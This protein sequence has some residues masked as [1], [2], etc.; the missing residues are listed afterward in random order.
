MKTK[1]PWM[2][3]VILSAILVLI[4]L[5]LNAATKYWYPS[6]GGTWTTVGNWSTTPSP[7]FTA[8][9]VPAAGDD[10]I[11]N[12][13]Q[14]ANITAVPAITLNSL[15]VTGNCLLASG[16]SGNTITI[17][18]SFFVAA[19]VTLT[20][21][22]SGGRIVFTLNGIG[23]S[24][25]NIAFDAGSTVRNFTVNGTLILLPTGRI[26]DPNLSVG[27]CLVVNSGATLKIGHSGGIL[28]GGQTVQNPNVSVCFGG[29]NTYNAGANFEY[30]GTVAQVTGAG[31]PATVSSLTINNAVGVTLTAAVA[32][33]NNLEININSKLN[34]G[35][36]TTST[37]GTLSFN[38]AG[39]VAGTWGYTGSGATNI[40]TTYFA[41]NTGR[42]TV[43]SGTAPACS[44][45]LT[46]ATNTDNQAFCTGYPITNITYATTGATGATVTGLPAGVTSA[47]ASNVLTISGSPAVSGNFTYQ[48]TLTGGG[49][50][51]TKT[52]TL[53]SNVFLSYPTPNTFAP[54]TTITSLTPTF[55]T[56][57]SITSYSISPAL[58]ATGLTFSTATGIISGTTGSSTVAATTYTV[59][60]TLSCGGSVSFGVVI[61]VGNNRYAVANGNWN[62]TS[63]WATTSGGTAGA[64]VPSAGDN[65]YIGEGAA[66]R[67]VT[68]PTTVTAVC[69][70][71]NIGAGANPGVLTFTDATNTLTVY[72]DLIMNVPTAAVSS[73]IN[74]NA[75]T[76]TVNGKASLSTDPTGVGATTTT[77][78]NRI[79]ISTGTVNIAGDLTFYALDVAQSNI[80]FSGAGVLNLGGNF[81]IPNSLGTITPSTGTVNFNGSS[82]T[83]TIPVGVSSITYSNLTV[84]NTSSGGAKLSAALTATNVTGNISVGNVTTA[85]LLYTNNFNMARAA[86]N[87]IT[88]ASGSTLNAGTSVISWGGAS[89]VITINGSMQTANTAG[90]TGS[91]TTAINTTNNAP[92]V[93]LGSSSTIEYNAAGAQA[94]TSRTYTNNVILSGSGN[95]TISTG[96]AITGNLS[97]T[98]TAVGLMTSGGTST[99]GTLTLG[100]AG[101]NSGSW[102]GTAA[103]TATYKNSTYF[104]TTTTGILNVTTPTC[105]TGTWLGLVSTDWNTASNWC[106]TVVPTA[107]S[108]ITI[109]SSA[110]LQ[111]VIGATGSV[112]VCRNITIASGASLT[113]TGSN[114]L[115]VYGNWTNSGT[116]T[117][118]SSTV[119]FT[120]TG[121]GNIGASNFNN[122]T[123][124][125]AGTKTAT[126][127]LTIAG[128]VSLTNNFTPGAFTHTVAGNWANSGTFTAT[129]STVNFNGG[130]SQS[131]GASNF[132]NITF[133]GAGSKTATGILS[134]AGN[135]DIQIGSTFVAG[136]FTHTAGGNW[137]KSG[138]FTATGSTINFNSS[139]AGQTIGASNFNN[140]TF[141]NAGVK[142]AGGALAIVGNITI[143]NNFSGGS[144]TH[145]LQ[146]DWT[147]NGTFTGN[148]STISLNGSN[149]Q[150]ISG[151]PTTFYNLTQ[152]G[153]GVVNLGVATAVTGTLGL[154]SGLIDIG[155]YNLTVG[156]TSGGSATS[157]V[158]TS[159]TGRLVQSIA[160]NITKTYPVGNAAYNPMTVTNNSGGSDNFSIYVA[161]GLITNANSA[162]T[163]NRKWYLF[164]D[165]AGTA[166]LTLAASYNS[167]ETGTGFDRTSSPQIGYFDGTSWAYQPATA[168]GTGPFTFTATGSASN[169]T[170]TAGFFALGSGDAFAASKLAVTGLNPVNPSLGVPNTAITVQSQNSLGVPTYVNSSTSF[171][172]SS[173]TTFTPASSGTISSGTYQ[174]ILTGISFTAIVTGATAT[175]TRSSG[176]TLSPGTS[177]PFN[178]YAANIYEP[179]ATE[180]WDAANGWRKSTDGGG[181]W[182]NP[183]TLPGSNIFANNDLIRIPAGIT[184]TANVTASFYSMVVLGT[185]NINNSGN[186]TVN[187]STLSDYNI[188]VNGTLKNSGGTLTNN[189]AGFPTELI[190]ITGGTYEHAMNGGSIPV[191]KWSSLNTT[192]STCNITGITSTA[193]T[194]LNQTFQNFTW[195]NGSQSVTQSL[196]A[197]LPVN[198]TL[199]LT[200][201]N[202][203]TGSYRVIVGLSGSV[204]QTSGYVIGNVRRFIAD[205]TA[206]TVVFPVG[207][208][209]GYSPASITFTGSVTGSG[210]LDATTTIAA[211]P[212]AS[213]LSQMKY[214]NRK[215]TITNSGVTGFTTYSPT[216]TFVDGDKTGTPTTANLV[217]RKLDG[218]TWAAT[219]AGIRSANSTQCTGLT[220]FS[221]FYIGEDACSSSNAIWLGTA[222]TDWNTPGNWCSGSVPVSTTNV[223]IPS[224]PVN[225]PVLSS[226]G[227]ACNDITIQSGASLTISGVYN[228][229]VKGNWSNSG[230][231]TAGI[232]TISFTGSLAQTITGATTFNNLTI[233][234]SAGVTAANDIAVNG[235]LALTS[236]NP[237]ATHGTLDMGSYTLNMSSASATITGDN[238][239]SGIVKRQHTFTPNVQYSF[240]SQY[241]TVTFLGTGT[242]PDELSCRITIGSYLPN[243]ADA[244][245]RY[246]SF[247][248]TGTTG[249][250]KVTLNLAYRDGSYASPELNGNS[251]SNL[252][253]WDQH[254][255]LTVEQHGKSN[256]SELNNWVGLSGLSMSYIA[257]ATLNSKYWGLAN[258]ATTKNTWAGPVSTDWFEI[259]NWTGGHVPSA[260]DDVLIPDV[261]TGSN[262]YPILTANAEIKTIEIALGA[263][264]TAGSN[265][266]T[267]NGYSGAWINNGT[268]IPGTGSVN[269]THGNLSHIVSVSGTGT[270][271]FYNLYFGANT[272][273]RPGSGTTMKISG[274]AS[275]E[276]SSI[277]DLSAVGNTVEYNG[278]DQYIVNP[279]TAGF[280]Y[281]GFYNLTLSGTGTKT[282][283]GG[284]EL[285]ISGNFTGNAVLDLGSTGRAAF[286]GTAAQNISGTVAPVFTNLTV[287]NTAGV[288]ATV[289]I[290]VNDTLHL[291]SGNPSSL[292][293]GTLNMVASNIL[294]LGAN[295]VTTGSGDATGIIT[296][297]HTFATNTFYTFGN[298]NQ[299]VLFPVVTGQ[300]LP[301]SLSYRVT[302]GTV[303][304]W[305]GNTPA[306]ITKRTFEIAKSAAGSGTKALF[307]FNY[308]DNELASGINESLLSIYSSYYS[309]GTYTVTDE[310]WSNYNTDLNFISIQDKNVASLPTS[311]GNFQV[312][313]APTSVTTLTWNGGNSADWNTTSNW[314]PNGAPSTT[315]GVLIPDANTTPNDPI[316]PVGASCKFLI[317]ETDGILNS[318]TDATLTIADGTIGDAWACESGGIFNAGN[319]TVTVSNSGSSTFA[320]ISGTTHFY[321][322][323]VA[324][325][326]SVRPAADCYM[327]IAGALSIASDGILAA[328]TNENTIEFNGTGQ[329]IPNPNGSTPGYHN[330][331]LS[332]S[333]T[334]TLPA[335]LNIFDELT[336]N[337][338]GTVSA[339][340]GT[341][342]LNGNAYGQVIGGTASISF[343]NLTIDNSDG[344]TIENNETVNGTLTLTNG[345]VTTNG[346]TLTI[347]SAGTITGATSSSYINGKLARIYTATGSKSFP[348]GKN[349]NYRSLAVLFTDLT[350]TSTVTAEQFE[351]TIPGA[352]PS[353]VTPF[354]GRYWTITE[355]GSSSATF[356][357]T[358]DGTGITNKA[359][360]MIK[361][362]G[363]TNA[364]FSVTG[365]APN[366]T[367]AG[368]TSF[369]N[370]ALGSYELLTWTGGSSA[371]WGTAANWNENTVPQSTDN[372]TVQ[373]GTHQPEITS[374]PSTPT[375]CNDLT[376]QSG[377]VVTIDAGKALTVNGNLTNDAGITG[378][379]IKADATGS[380]SLI[381]NSASVDATVERYIANDWKWHFLSS[382]NRNQPIWP[383]FA[384]TPDLTSPIGWTAASS[385]PYFTSDFYY[386]NP[387]CPTTG[388]MW[389]NLRYLLNGKKG[390]YNDR[391]YEDPSDNGGF[392]TSPVI[393]EF[394]VGKGYMVAFNSSDWTTM[395]SFTGKLNTGAVPSQITN[396]TS[397]GGSAFNLVGNPYPSCID[398]KA[399]WNRTGLSPNSGG[400]YDYWVWNDTDGNYGVFNSG[401]SG[402]SG[403]HSVT[404]YIA[405]MQAFFI[406]AGSGTTLEMDNTLRTHA[407]QNWLKDPVAADNVVRLK[408]STDANPFNDEILIEFNPAFSGGGSNKFWSMYPESP[409][410][411]TVKSGENYSIDRYN[412]FN[413]D[414]VVAISTKCGVTGNYTIT[415][416]DITGF[417]L[418]DRVILE[419]LKTGSKVDLKVSNSYTFHGTPDDSRDRFKLMFR[420]G[421]GMHENLTGK[422]MYFYT[423]GDELYIN[424]ISQNPGD[425][426]VSIFDA[427]GR[428][429]YNGRIHAIPG[430]Q[431]VT[432]IIIPGTYIV[433]AITKTGVTTE[434]VLVH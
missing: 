176:E 121:T 416:P 127:V 431:H 397:Q 285:D 20:L 221:D 213:G 434:K 6:S 193:V 222:S 428:K 83:Q 72:G 10:I 427:L 248:Q 38:G 278:G 297:T 52:G 11:I 206:P 79:N 258:S 339:G 433:K 277:V 296:R 329:T 201:G 2:M 382:P 263:S 40:N 109:P 312:G 195:A 238:D 16:T 362:D 408:F 331:I 129:G 261:S 166:N 28:P 92:T 87:T 391:A 230:T 186:L 71:L 236:T 105:T 348:T 102:G 355:S 133:S 135:V 286:I 101:Q 341:V 143:S 212:F 288:S 363:T 57:V 211:P 387:Y 406:K 264:V 423:A 308:L 265:D 147:N 422:Q 284:N 175:V 125:G 225:Q 304:S 306:N 199:T 253:L 309:G 54:N 289:N 81:Y 73:I 350:G 256:S 239:V 400:G 347:G 152:N 219:T 168:S 174:T 376:I 108:D 317:I 374:G 85:S 220:S 13:N 271:Q 349:G 204:S 342:I 299:G 27:S 353:N 69:N 93:T 60:A 184:L 237:N 185:L 41:S 240:G 280:S 31:F 259:G 1:S 165:A 181:T 103:T 432:S 3:Y 330:L 132:N 136:A 290:T 401:S 115:S 388:L 171:D 293:K 7:T 273:I 291:E 203:T 410:L 88:I 163:V 380:G 319:S 321:N 205:A 63:T 59:T 137:T 8:T 384:S 367:H 198:G 155:A 75:G 26:Y 180:S 364:V 146:G 419:D 35:T 21:G 161:D 112:F 178:V 242:Q 310:G 151:S 412:T 338:T 252:C 197:D 385:Q 340:S 399:V 254:P 333:G 80:T 327:Y 251:E 426:D 318:A 231:F 191:C 326:S 292:D 405:P 77:F 307:R 113:I 76:L 335:T 39:Q 266:L 233:N 162:K 65:V 43:A 95:K 298:T 365:T 300:T 337:A 302:I 4:S 188:L 392:G 100:G 316:L 130:G 158:K 260:T 375:V 415:A 91:T 149:P 244:V 90:F 228:L 111:P 368:F 5:Q 114:T 9:T 430:K 126:G 18:S 89:G 373:T 352:A 393:P 42:I 29:T 98:G 210:Y 207:D 409:E 255:N 78:V 370:F 74:L 208:G 25:G 23:T 404:Q 177:A 118:N 61:A 229:D 97:I 249:T 128:N 234:N 30:I 139:S 383:N 64:S 53:N 94:V 378:L 418:C 140:I 160:Y 96:T 245:L 358:L 324:T 320:S 268:F 394:I 269:F 250:D 396:Y 123:F 138:T 70:S 12:S 86:S 421:T 56:A 345:L 398:W 411:Y 45:N 209:S 34:L 314:T 15:T 281:S 215:W 183:A 402:G 33:T 173:T 189:N 49:C 361:G 276:T 247:A 37:A 386:F 334:M 141:S 134:I 22:I 145:T 159:G 328:A 283:Y 106:G 58:T 356:D 275:G 224:S 196:S 44:I 99:A 359:V 172:L 372:V 246:Y 429:I 381:S 243:K 390:T 294:Y 46:S 226:A 354:T 182:T 282:L 417:G 379:V 51:T 169:I 179:V 287:N 295:A 122:I 119:D 167:G 241:T 218:T 322:F 150:T 110:P 68:I 144:Y 369:S 24:A 227:K 120:G 107:T 62:A 323:S 217:I 19:G 257:P 420:Y 194:G 332:G 216:F 104:G 343:N 315:Y 67:T 200:S 82:V 170:S 47:W 202:I 413:E 425:C 371:D 311:L 66:S 346:N 48:V 267:I 124:S 187:H 360:N 305:G 274:L 157:Y 403:T 301:T 272:F 156:S 153:L 131:I 313:I 36:F 262:R 14:T 164:K 154:N 142:T 50:T 325:G 117:P 32:V 148:T 232:G 366:Y 357:L 55:N 279:S 303:P 395:H 351:S 235:I 17:T 192:A 414:V 407:A 344:V 270:N 336:N 116:F 84:N 389:V 214:I 377:A 223:T 190:E 424:S